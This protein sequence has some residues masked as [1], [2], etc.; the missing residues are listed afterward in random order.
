MRN[1]K[2]SKIWKRTLAKQSDDEFESEREY[3]RT[4]FEKFREHTEKV[5][6]EI[7]A[8]LPNYTVHDITHIDAL[9]DT[10][11]LIISESYSI[12]PAEAFVLGG[13]FLLHDLG[14]TLA[15]YS[16]GLDELKNEQI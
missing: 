13:A 11:D 9:W 8:I 12:N 1:Y 16:G 4:N 14:M 10:T 7:S 3:L 15:A 5:A 2:Q 6:G